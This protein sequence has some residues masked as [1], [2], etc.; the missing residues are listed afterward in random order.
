MKRLAIVLSLALF[1]SLGKTSAQDATPVENPNAPD[2]QFENETYDFGTIN[3]G[4]KINFEYKFKN[5][6]KEPL[7]ITRAKGS[8]G[9]TVPEW[10]KEPIKAGESGIIKVVFN[11]AGKVGKQ[12]KTLTL[13]SNAKT[14][15][16]RLFLVGTV[17]GKVGTTPEVQEGATEG[18]SD[19]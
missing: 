6:G 14:P 15:A 8:C 17:I 10:P 7:I 4:D 5:I 1:I 16:K 3:E 9:C 18:G 12:R 2:F 13:N 11:S 19:Q